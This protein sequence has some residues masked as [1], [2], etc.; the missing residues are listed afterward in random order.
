MRVEARVQFLVR[1]QGRCRLV[2]DHQVEAVEVCLVEPKGLPDNSLDPIARRRLPAVFLGDSEPQAGGC[3][4]PVARQYRK[5]FIPAAPCFFENAIEIGPVTEPLGLSEGMAAARNQ[6]A[7][8]QTAVAAVRLRRQACTTLG[9]AP[10]DDLAAR[11]GSH[12]GAEAVGTG[13][14]EF[15]GLESAFHRS[16]PWVETW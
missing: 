3:V 11:L 4:L 9:A 13:A 10:L 2:H 5:T 12:T 1:C 16:K 6:G 15:A 7:R 14:L 8:Y